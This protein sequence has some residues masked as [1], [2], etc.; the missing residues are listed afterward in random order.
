M[1]VV[2]A[3]A[4]EPVGD[5]NFPGE[6]ELRENVP[7]GPNSPITIYTA[8]IVDSNHCWYNLAGDL[9]GNCEVNFADF[10]LMAADWRDVGSPQEFHK[11]ELDCNIDPPEFCWE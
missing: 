11:N 3:I 4:A 7:I 2:D 9:D 8:K 10:A 5:V 1:N 6:P